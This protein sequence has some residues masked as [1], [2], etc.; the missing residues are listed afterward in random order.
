M[1]RAIVALALVLVLGGCATVPTTPT[2]A[3]DPGRL[4][5]WRATG[6]MALAVDGRGGSGSF[7]WQQRDLATTLSIRGPLGAGA[8]QIVA[9]GESIAA[10]DGEGRSV[11]TEPARA[12]L[13]ERLG[14]DLPIAELRYW[15]LGLPAPDSP[16]EVAVAAGTPSR[17]IEQSGWRIGYDAFRPTDGLSLPARFSAVQGDVRLKVVIDDW[18]LP[19]GSGPGP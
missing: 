12:M 1:R 16:A 3:V 7:T 15:M 13:R 17:V 2:A 14:A 11:D 18:T 6:R 8:M 4:R 5:E 10:T 9:E 19:V